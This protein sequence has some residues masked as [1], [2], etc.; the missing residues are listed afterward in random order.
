MKTNVN[1]STKTSRNLAHSWGKVELLCG[2]LFGSKRLLLVSKKKMGRRDSKPHRHLR[3]FV[4]LFRIY[5]RICGFLYTWRNFSALI[6]VNLFSMKYSEYMDFGE[7]LFFL[8]F[9]VF[10]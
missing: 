6:F 5:V 1:E 8:H 9:C 2:F 3:S 4:H 10:L 7:A